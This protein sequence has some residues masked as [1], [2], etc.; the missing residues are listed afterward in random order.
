VS[1]NSVLFSQMATKLYWTREETGCIIELLENKCNF[2]Q[3]GRMS[4]FKGERKV[5]ISGLYQT[6]VNCNTVQPWGYAVIT[7]LEIPLFI[8]LPVPSYH[9]TWQNKGPGTLMHYKEQQYIKRCRNHPLFNLIPDNSLRSYRVESVT[10]NESNQYPLLL[11]SDLNKFERE[12]TCNTSM[13]CTLSQNGGEPNNPKISSPGVQRRR[14]SALWKGVHN[15]PSQRDEM[16]HFERVSI[17]PLLR[18]MRW[19]T[20][21]ECP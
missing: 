11:S 10:K 5:D 8:K 2:Q 21:K 15:S 12:V 4:L 6:E 13:V 17:T 20:L 7:Q 1:R 19:N 14:H 3:K 18:E 16:K 9:S